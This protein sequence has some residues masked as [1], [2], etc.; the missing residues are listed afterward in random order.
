[1]KKTATYITCL[2]IFAL[3]GSLAVAQT[4]TPQQTQEA[5]LQAYI[6]MLRKDLKKDKVSVIT[7]M[8]EARTFRRCQVLAGLQRVRQVPNQTGG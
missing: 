1:M 5:N 8:M 4:P 7:E 3:A 2:G 6:S